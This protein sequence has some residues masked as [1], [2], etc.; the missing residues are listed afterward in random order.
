MAIAGQGL[1]AVTNELQTL[2][3]KQDETTQ[4][5]ES[6]VKLI[7]DQIQQAERMRLDQLEAAAEASKQGPIRPKG[8]SGP[9]APPGG[10]TD[11]SFMLLPLAGLMT[12][13]KT[14]AIPAIIAVTA[15]ITGFD[16]VIRGLTLPRLFTR[17]GNGFT[18]IADAFRTVGKV[19]DDFVPR[20]RFEM[21][22][23]TL[24]ALPDSVKNFKFPELKIPPVFKAG[25]D[26][27]FRLPESFRNF[28]F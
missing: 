24:F 22:K 10:G 7:A 1:R 3:D 25:D 14:L 18:R 28:K 23:R 15:S 6:V 26:G 2:T 8:G 27:F 20:I 9:G 11:V 17:I 21:P 4:S 5:V 19:I 13:L 16:D 12:A